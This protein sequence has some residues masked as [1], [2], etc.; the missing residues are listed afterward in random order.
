MA[1]ASRA[2]RA[3]T[4]PSNP[5]AHAICQRCGFRYNHVDLSWQFDYRGRELRNL[6]LLV[7]RDCYDTPFEHW[8]PIITGP[9]P[10]PIQDPR[11]EN[12]AT[13]EALNSFVW[14]NDNVV[15]FYFSDDS[16]NMINWTGAPLVMESLP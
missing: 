11:P 9:D 15:P 8:R 10:V 3:R 14:V 13:A 5:Q 12:Y 7:C 16:G 1:Y 2:G 4:D 6:K